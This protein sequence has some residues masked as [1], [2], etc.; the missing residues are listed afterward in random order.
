MFVATGVA[1]GA[2]ACGP[3]S[4]THG[5]GAT[6]TGGGGSTGGST[7]SSSTTSTTTVNCNALGDGGVGSFPFPPVVAAGGHMIAAPKVVTVTFMGDTYASQLADY[8][9]TAVANSYWDAVRAGYCDSTGCVGDGPAGTAVALNMAAGASYTDPSNGGGTLQTLLQSL[10]TANT[11]PQ[12]DDN[13]IYALYFPESTKI[14]QDGAMSCQDYDGY[15]SAMQVGTQNVYYAVIPECSAPPMTPAITTLQNTTI[16]AAHELIETATDND[17]GGYYLD[18][19]Q[20]ST[21]GWD[22][23]QGGEV[24]DLCVDP[25]GLGLDEATENGFTVQRSW[26]ITNATAGKN[27]C[28]PVPAGEVYFNTYPQYS[29][30]VMD[31]GASKTIELEALSDGT[32]PAWTVIPEDWTDYTGQNTW[33]SFSLPCGGTSGSNGPQIQM[34]SGQKTLLTITLTADPANAPYQEVDGVIVSANS[35]DMKA[36]TAAH[37]WPFIVL[38]TAQAGDAGGVMQKRARHA[39][40]AKSLKRPRRIRNVFG[41]FR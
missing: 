13:T 2:S 1:V 12:P 24:A 39:Q 4:T 8:G 10:I 20:L 18:L 41:G 19:N 31:V 38:S 17:N 32:M 27:P 11:V 35:P 33:L 29:V 21:Y 36:V 7:T 40:H 26:S 23:I 15:H 14:T 28:V 5:T 3:S 9:T 16:T 6:S 30:I 22:D 34:Q 25:F 37:W